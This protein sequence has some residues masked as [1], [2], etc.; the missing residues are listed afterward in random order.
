MRDR[1][2]RRGNY[3]LISPSETVV[4]PPPPSVVVILHT[5]PILVLVVK[6]VA[7]VIVII[8]VIAVVVSERFA[9]SVVDRLA[10]STARALAASRVGVS[11]RNIKRREPFESPREVAV[12][13]AAVWSYR[14]LFLEINYPWS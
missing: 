5:A 9:D 1:R 12:P 10:L 13:T 6:I 11:R 8:E 3:G 7:V 2:G 4:A 14:Y